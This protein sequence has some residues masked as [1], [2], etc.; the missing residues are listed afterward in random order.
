[1]RAVPRLL[2]AAPMGAEVT[3]P[4]FTPD[5]TTLFLSVQHPGEDSETF[6]ALTTRWPDFDDK[7]PPRPSVIAITRK[8]GGP[9]GA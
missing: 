6:A 8:A 4:C 7:T 5:G 1:M 3:G 2:Y 9:V